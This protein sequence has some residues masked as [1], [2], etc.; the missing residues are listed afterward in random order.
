MEQ[1]RPDSERS[2]A[3]GAGASRHPGPLR[4]TGG[5]KQGR[6][7][8]SGYRLETFLGRGQYGEVWSATGPGR[9]S[10]ALKF[11]DLRGAQG[12]KEFRGIQRVKAIRHAH[13]MPI[14][15]L[16]LIADDGTVATDDVLDG[17]NPADDT[18][19]AARA[20]STLME[21][22][23]PRV[24]VVAMLLA[25]RSLEDRLAECQRLGQDGI[26]RDELLGYMEDAAKGLDFLN[27]PGHDL[28][29][30]PVAI[31]HCDV[32][33]ANLVL[34]GNS[35]LVC[36]FGLA[37]LLGDVS[38][39]ATG[40][41]GSL[42][43]MAPENIARRPSRAS[44]QY[45][46]AVTYYELRT[47]R[48]PFAN[49]DVSTVMDAHQRGRLDFSAVPPGE[50]EVLHRATATRPELRFADCSEFVRELSRADLSPPSRCTLPLPRSRRR[51][52]ALSISA[53]LLLAC[54]VG[55]WAALSLLIPP[56]GDPRPVPA[57]SML[58]LQPAARRVLVDGVP[59][60][61]DASGRIRLPDGLDGPIELRIPA[62]DGEHLEYVRSFTREELATLEFR[63][64]YAF[65]RKAAQH[66]DGD[67]RRRAGAS[68]Q[69]ARQLA[70]GGRFDEAV[71]LL[72]SAIQVDEQQAAVP[73]PNSTLP[74][75]GTRCL[76]M[77]PKGRLLVTGGA[78]NRLLLWDLDNLAAPPKALAQLD[79][80]IGALAVSP[81][82]RWVACGLSLG[83]V[84]VCE[85]DAAAPR[86][87]ELLGHPTQVRALKFSPDDAALA[88]TTAKG[89]VTPPAIHLWNLAAD[90]PEA[91]HRR[92][93]GHA[94]NVNALAFSH[95]SRWLYSGG[96]DNR[97]LRW[98]AAAEAPQPETIHDGPG[99]IQ[100]LACHSAK[101]IVAFG[102][103]GASEN[104]MVRTSAGERPRELRGHTA[105]IEVVVFSSQGDRLATSDQDGFTLVWNC[106]D[107][108][109]SARLERHVGIVAD[110]EFI[111]PGNWLA[112]ASWDQTVGLW[113]LDA[114]TKTPLLLDH[115]EKLTALRA[116]SDGR[117]LA[118]LAEDGI[119]R[120]WSIP[121]LKLV[122]RACDELG[123][124][125]LRPQH[126]ASGVMK[127]WRGR[128]DASHLASK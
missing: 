38:A 77:L 22:S 75:D 71:A 6:E 12:L 78:D 14:T 122:K 90:R 34:V 40:L 81:G 58:T 54:A 119:V 105:D 37:R 30:G 41:L 124:I 45:A 113:D 116:S 3:S 44:D 109:V 98:D 88:A 53:V 21:K 104:L 91:T 15:G 52:A 1:H 46:L 118:T 92:L 79:G 68:A 36:D 107:F 8:I 4:L 26:P 43:Y 13:L 47:G 115:P 5:L 83:R 27:T 70:D 126:Q 101:G 17:Y 39:T 86:Q 94:E 73:L 51:W 50:R 32:K 125:P 82:G 19:L 18:V 2:I 89:A 57:Q 16:W 108:S 10:V 29:D 69:R 84:F 23:R 60:E 87:F 9:V 63:V 102:G 76:A 24:L 55:I 33:P 85:L 128:D 97:V 117:W 103:I 100:A 106:T 65:P 72:K 80:A 48:L 95:D 112:T 93:E 25:S 31:Q 56:V 110:A 49:E 96:F 42:A 28:G 120:V 67:P 66:A 114:G 35:V 11:I 61:A 74:V 111:A 7:P 64:E 20:V 121:Q 59:V 62:P 123:Q 99:D 127:V